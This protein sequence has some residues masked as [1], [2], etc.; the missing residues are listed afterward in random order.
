MSKLVAGILCFAFGQI[1]IWYQTNGQFVWKWADEHPGWMAAIT[2]K[3]AA[4][5]SSSTIPKLSPPVAGEQKMSAA[6]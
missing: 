5:A 4:I 2:G 6:W 1:L 3:P